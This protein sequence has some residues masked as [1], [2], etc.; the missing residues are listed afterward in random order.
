MTPTQAKSLTD[1]IARWVEARPD[2]KSLALV[3]S[4]ACNVARPDSDIDL[5]VLADDPAAYRSP[6]NWLAPALPQS[7]RVLSERIADYGAVWSCHAMLAPDVE[8]ELS[9]GPLTWAAT[10]PLDAGTWRVVQG[11]FR[12]LVDKDGR[13][14]RLVAAVD[15]RRSG[16]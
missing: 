10:D 2:L 15:S 14:Q 7:F 6:R 11:G 13:L 1:A 12:I 8:L 5:L 9:F 4:W 16:S 3:G